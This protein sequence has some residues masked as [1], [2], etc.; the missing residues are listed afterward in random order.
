[1][2]GRQKEIIDSLHEGLIVSCQVK[3]DD[4]LYMPGICGKLADAALWGGA[5]GLRA[6][7]PEDIALIR[8]RT[9]VPII[10]LWKIRI[11][12][13]PVFITPTMDAVEAVVRSGADI[14]AVDATDRLGHS[15]EKAYNIIS[16]IKKAY[17]KHLILADIRN[18]EEAARAADLGAHMAAPTL[19]R[20]GDN[21]KSTDNPDFEML[22]KIVKACK[23]KA[24]VI[25]EG[26]ITTPEEALESLY[27]GA[28][29]VVVGNAITRPHIT[30]LRFTSKMGRFQKKV[31]LIY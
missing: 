8:S 11:Q 4:P 13:S 25:M 1:M 26:K 14:I 22:S 2:T 9:D 24:L 3:K 29:A 10:G 12:D 21:P 16:E 15:G 28:H 27:L 6:D 20:F 30:A 7:G 5:V 18:D 17:P 19:Y 31:P 23:G